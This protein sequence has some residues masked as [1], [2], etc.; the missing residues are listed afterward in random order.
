M[1]H[2]GL[3]FHLIGDYY[4][5]L[6]KLML[7]E[8]YDQI[9]VTYSQA[10]QVSFVHGTLVGSKFKSEEKPLL[11]YQCISIVLHGPGIHHA[12]VHISKLVEH[13]PLLSKN[14]IPPNIF[15]Q[16]GSVYIFWFLFHIHLLG[17][18]FPMLFFLFPQFIWINNVK[19][20]HKPC[21]LCPQ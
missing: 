8:P 4:N 19:G 18:L 12:V 3:L 11:Y 9:G 21:C 2:L 14:K 16:F 6:S 13:I 10:L 5:L 17:R 20:D 1:A 15:I 7:Q